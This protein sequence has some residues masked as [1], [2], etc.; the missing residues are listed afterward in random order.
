MKQ[1]RQPK[2]PE[3]LSVLAAR[4]ALRIISTIENG[5]NTPGSH[6]REQVLAERFHVSRSPVREALNALIMLEVVEHHR[7]RGCFVSPLSQ[8]R[9]RLARKQLNG[10]DDGG[11]EATYRKIAAMRL[12]GKLSEVF[13]EADLRR[14]FGLSHGEVGRV[15]ERMSREGWIERRPGY[16]WVFVKI[17]TTA[18]SLDLSYRFRR[19]LEPAA[20]LE[21]TFQ[22]DPVLFGQVRAEQEAI[23][24]GRLKLASSV[25]L[26][27]LGS[28][29]HEVLVQCS[30]NPHFLDAVQRVNRLR[31]LLEYRA[32]VDTRR[33][34]TQ[35]REHLAI[36]DLVEAGRMQAASE[37][38][39]R[40]LDQV[41]KVKLRSLRETTKS[42]PAASVNTTVHLHF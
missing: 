22:A 8:T 33:F 18:G 11:E 17:L 5:E 35:A 37:Y 39:D 12:D 2:N 29:F 38:M 4:I 42:R 32:M 16:G 1:P 10:S 7:H 14:R 25:E 34:L 19:A 20:L 15:V 31:R 27:E 28:R 36:L 3:P 6:L 13:S 9:L 30:G 23:V 21:P 41:L 26:F 40:H 24:E